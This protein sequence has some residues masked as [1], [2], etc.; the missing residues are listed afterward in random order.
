MNSNS[1][2]DRSNS[3]SILKRKTQKQLQDELDEIQRL[4]YELPNSFLGL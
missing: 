2:S 1:G 3:N 4:D